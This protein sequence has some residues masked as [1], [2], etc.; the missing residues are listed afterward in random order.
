MPLG[1]SYCQRVVLGEVPNL[2]PDTGADE[3]V[4]DLDV[5]ARAGLGAY[6]GVPIELRDGTVYGTL[7]AASHRPNHDLSERDVEFLRTISRRLAL[8]L[9]D[10]R[11]SDS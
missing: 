6:V 1:E 10:R 2:I 7:C 9:E 11:L 5:T 8:T 3:R 4:R